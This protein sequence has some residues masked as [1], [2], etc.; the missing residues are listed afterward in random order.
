MKNIV[1]VILIIGMITGCATTQRYAIPADK[2]KVNFLVDKEDCAASSGYSG[3]SFLIGPLIII[4]PVVIVLELIKA[5][6]QKVF[7][8]CMI[9]RGYRCTDGCWNSTP[10][11]LRGQQNTQLIY[12]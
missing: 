7:E 10:E 5:K 6:H 11:L 2:D 9:E 3:G 4:F 1:T 8:R 12:E